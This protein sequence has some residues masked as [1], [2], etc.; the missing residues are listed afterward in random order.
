[1]MC[2]AHGYVCRVLQASAAAIIRAYKQCSQIV[3]VEQGGG[4]G[5]AIL[6]GDTFHPSEDQ[7][8][9]A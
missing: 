6:K 4:G 3:A 2:I 5:G 1:M 8:I 7:Y 9:K